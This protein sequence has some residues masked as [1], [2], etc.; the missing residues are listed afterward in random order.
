MQSVTI[1]KK[2]MC[3]YISLIFVCFYLFDH[4]GGVM[5]DEVLCCIDGTQDVRDLHLKE[6]NCTDEA[7]KQLTG[8][9]KVF[10]VYVQ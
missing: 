6:F 3:S 9:S 4:M 8:L 10:V 5:K 7:I 1:N 2:K